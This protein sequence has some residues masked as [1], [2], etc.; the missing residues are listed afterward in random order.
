MG[1]QYND[2][3]GERHWFIALL[4]GPE[5]ETKIYNVAAGELPNELT[6]DERDAVIQASRLSEAQPLSRPN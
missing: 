3:A 5:P 6:V 4:A 1:S 2:E